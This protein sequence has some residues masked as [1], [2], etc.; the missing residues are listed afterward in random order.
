MSS[1]L[2]SASGSDRK[3]ARGSASGLAGASAVMAAPE[4]RAGRAREIPVCRTCD[5]CST[6]V[7]LRPSCLR[8]GAVEERRHGRVGS[9]ITRIIAP[10]TSGRSMRR[11]L[12]AAGMA[13]PLVLGAVVMA[14]AQ[15]GPRSLGAAAVDYARQL[16]ADKEPGTWMSTGR[17][18]DEQRFS[19]LTQ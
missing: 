5:A 7:A 10:G 3:P 9:A 11:S 2:Q 8:R 15:G 1:L 12:I 17:T 14:F 13:L 19:P 16:A 18:Y 4:L 6:A